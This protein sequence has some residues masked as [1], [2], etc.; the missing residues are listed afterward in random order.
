MVAKILG[1]RQLVFFC[2]LTLMM[3]LSHPGPAFSEAWLSYQLRTATFEMPA[4]WKV[5]D[6][7]RD[8]E[9]D[10]T[11]PD[12]SMTIWVRW[13]F[14][15]EPLTGF[16]DVLSHE[17]LTLAGQ[18][19]LLVR[20][21]SGVDRS[22]K[23]A[24]QDTDEEGELLLVQ[25]FS[26]TASIEQLEDQLFRILKRM[27]VK[28]IPA[29]QEQDAATSFGEQSPTYPPLKGYHYNRRGDFSFAALPGWSFK[30]GRSDGA[31]YTFALSAENDAA[32]LVAH[33]ESTSGKTAKAILDTYLGYLYRNS[34]LVKSI[35]AESDPILAGYYFHAIDVVA[36]LYEIAGTP[37]PFDRGRVTI[38]QGGTD[39]SGF[40]ILTFRKEKGSEAVVPILRRIT[41]SL[42]IGQPVDTSGAMS[43][44]AEGSED[45]LQVIGGSDTMADNAP[46]EGSEWQSQIEKRLKTQCILRSKDEWDHPTYSV[47]VD[48][49]V[50]FR[51]VMQCKDF[52]HT[53]F[54]VS[55][56]YDMRAKTDDYFHPLYF[57][58]IKANNGR[59]FSFLE[60]RDYLLASLRR[61]TNGNLLLDFADLDPPDPTVTIART[62]DP[63][64]VNTEPQ[65]QPD[66]AKSQI[67]DY[68]LQPQS[69]ILFDGKSLGE[70]WSAMNHYKN[71]FETL[72]D[73]TAQGLDIAWQPEDKV[74]FL[75]IYSKDPVLWLERFTQGAEARITYKLDGASS[76]GLV[77]G[78]RQ[79]Y[80]NEHNVLGNKD[81]LLSWVQ[82]TNRR[83]RYQ[84]RLKT[85][86]KDGQTIDDV[87]QILDTFTLI[88]RPSGITVE[89][90]GIPAFELPY[91]QLL[92]GAGLRFWAYAISDSQKAGRLTLK[93]ISYEYKRGEAEQPGS[94][95]R[96]VKPLEVATFFDGASTENWEG[97]DFGDVKFADLSTRNSGEISLSRRA[98]PPNGNRIAFASKGPV[99]KLDERIE[100]TPYE[101]E[102]TINPKLSNLS[103]RIVLTDNPRNYV[104]AANIAITLEKLTEGPHTGKTKL[105]LHANHFFYGFWSRLLPEG[106][107]DDS[108]DGKL[109][110][111]F[112]HKWF[113]VSLGGDAYITVNSSQ[114]ARGRDYH[115]VFVPGGLWY[116]T[117]GEISIRSVTGG[118][119]TPDGMTEM[120]RQ[121]LVDLDKFDADLFADMLASERAAK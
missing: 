62:K 17:K 101:V 113:R 52:D 26:T 110:L 105:T 118:W 111:T 59:P 8:Q 13:W 54:G 24:F 42:T 16:S 37:V 28:G 10:F 116:R 11:S 20:S 73:F 71:H 87:K 53:V 36:K 51:F 58:M 2:L 21:D 27:L 49:G 74:N 104:K 46:P 91:E 25:L 35:K 50:D 107:V 76:K 75:G 9:Y 19:A 69:G 96:N 79:S 56:R 38:Y 86:E 48:A 120:E 63:D 84:H 81:Y 31:D 77:I 93:E 78:L 18:D 121:H 4:N 90:K 3:Q 33:A 94:P 40:V 108:W 88:L 12:N 100:R 60:V 66:T 29:L 57:N 97:L 102:I 117:P 70:S 61:E 68:M 39:Y 92:D 98:N 45:G 89:A 32:I 80:A 106:L 83:F 95:A 44:E 67:D 47:M 114:V 6:H 64:I 72:A 82:Q 65:S 23:V 41:E 34:V 112:G 43:A 7:W 99:I 55:F 115:I 15:D 119:K 109:T 14:P 30:D 5:K 1:T 103:G 85:R 22:V